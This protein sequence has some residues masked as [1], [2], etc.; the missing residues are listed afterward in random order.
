MEM[1]LFCGIQAT[2]KTTFFKDNFFKTHI[3]ISFDQLRTR[4]REGKFI[5]TCFAT[6]QRFVVDNTN[7]TKLDRQKYIAAAK[8]SKFKVIS[9]FFRSQLDEAI[10]RNSKREGKENIPEIGIRG[11][12]KKFEIP[13]FD[14]G[15]DELFEVV[16]EDNQFVIRKWNDENEIVEN[17]TD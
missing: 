10:K 1:I 2:G 17:H 7:P 11:T 12:F 5:D 14:E 4:N 13:S 3:R 9:Y 8:A 16:I 15:F 6:Q